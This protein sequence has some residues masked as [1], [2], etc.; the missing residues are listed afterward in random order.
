MAETDY[1]LDIV[2]EVKRLL[3]EQGILSTRADEATAEL[4]LDVA[5]VQ[6]RLTVAKV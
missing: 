6:H 3:E 4:V 2:R 5:G 1:S